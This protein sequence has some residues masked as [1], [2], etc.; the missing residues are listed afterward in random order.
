MKIDDFIECYPHKKSRL[1]YHI[2]LVTK[3]RRRCLNAIRK[4]VI[5]AFRDCESKSDIKIHRMNIDKDHIHFI[6]SFPTKYSIDQ[7]I[8][9]LKQF[10][11]NYI[12]THCN[13]H[14]RHFYWKKK[15][16]LWSDSYFCSTIGQVSESIVDEYIKN[17]G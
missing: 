12:Y 15:R 9:R 16:A 1:R 14:I 6:I 4:E 5:A 8:R 10:S 3:Y 17:Q 7:T 11:T 2:I 13:E